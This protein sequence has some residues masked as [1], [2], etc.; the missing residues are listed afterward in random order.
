MK[1]TALWAL[2]VL[3]AVLLSSFI[4]RLVPDNKAFAQ[5]PAVRRASDYLMLPAV[6]NGAAS[7]IVVAL[8]QTNSQLSAFSYDESSR[9]IVFMTKVDLRRAFQGAP[10]V[11]APRGAGGRQN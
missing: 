2:I 8:D 11:P 5:Q 3:N 10:A 9:K 7:G 6:L 1:S 4:W